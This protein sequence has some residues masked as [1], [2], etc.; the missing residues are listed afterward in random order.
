VIAS[1][2]REEKLTN[3]VD[4]KQLGTAV[5]P[6]SPTSPTPPQVNP[7]VPTQVNPASPKPSQPSIVAGVHAAA[8]TNPK[9]TKYA[10]R[11]K[12]T[13]DIT[14]PWFRCLIHGEIDSW[15]T[16]TAHLF[17]TPEQT[18]TI[19]VRGEDQLEPIIKKGYKFLQ[20]N[21]GAE[22]VDVLA[23]C[24]LIWPDWAKHPEPVLIID[25]LSRAKDYVV[26]S[27]KTYS[28]DSGEVKEYKDMRKVYGTAL[29][30]FDS[31]FTI[32]NKKPMHIIL[33]ATSKVVEGKISLEET[34]SPDLSQAIGTFV[35][36][37]YSFIFFLNKKN[38]Y[39]TRLLTAMTN[40]AITEY[41]EK[42]KKNVTYQRYYFARHKIPVEL[43]G[44]GFIKL[45]EPADLRAVWEK[46]KSAN[47]Q[48][49]E[50]AK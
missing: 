4:V 31:V 42:Q 38:P 23:N 10:E 45:Y 12:S 43:A 11:T 15:K 39:Q 33:I 44:K 19:L 3:F 17:G 2:D 27:S 41:D 40:E 29:A 36:S 49:K 16:T 50:A 37:D 30:E 14:S 34:V 7:A 22:F 24:D 6:P 13:H 18:R 35:M 21:D 5:T 1:K 26:T 25:D 48:V 9:L 32:A 47:T 20:V 46:I 8:R 28:T